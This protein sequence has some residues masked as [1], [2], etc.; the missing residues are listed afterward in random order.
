MAGDE[1]ILAEPERYAKSL[2]EPIPET[3]EYRGKAFG[4]TADGNRLLFEFI[5]YTLVEKK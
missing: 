4:T 1:D 5:N 3:Q 2:K